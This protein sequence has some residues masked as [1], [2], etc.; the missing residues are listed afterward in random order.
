MDSL[1]KLAGI[2]LVLYSLVYGMLMAVPQLAILE[3]SIRNLYYHVPMWFGM[4]FLFLGSAV[5]SIMFL[6]NQKIKNDVWAVEFARIGL[7]FGVLGMITG[8]LWALVTWG[9]FWSNDPKQNASAIALLIYF[10]YFV[11]RGAFKDQFTKAKFS[12]IYNIFAFFAIIPLIF[13]LPRMTDSLH[14]G[15]GGNPGFSIY[16]LDNTMRWVFYPAVVGFTLIGFWL[17]QIGYRIK[18]LKLPEND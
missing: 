2:L 18:I 15:S 4:I 13:V 12:A 17:A 3:E 11:F 1:W 14:P 7:V 5:S 9:D 8:M 16:D 10:A 6:N